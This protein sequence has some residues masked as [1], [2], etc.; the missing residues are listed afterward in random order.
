MAS[1]LNGSGGTADGIEDPRLQ[2][3]FNKPV[4]IFHLL[5]VIILCSQKCRFLKFMAL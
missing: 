1:L 3:D 4:R 2:V 5:S